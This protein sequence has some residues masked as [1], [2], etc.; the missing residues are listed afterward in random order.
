MAEREFKKIKDILSKSVYASY[1][2]KIKSANSTLQTLVEQSEYRENIWQKR[3]LPKRQLL[4]IKTTRRIAHSLYDIIARGEF[5]NCKCRDQHRAQI[6]LDVFSS[7]DFSETPE[8]PKFR[9]MLTSKTSF[10]PPVPWHWQEV[11]TES[12]IKDTQPMEPKSAS[13]K[14]KLSIT[15]KAKVKFAVVAMPL[16]SVPWPKV[17]RIP[18]GSPIENLCTTLCVIKAN[19]MREDRKLI[20]FLTDDNHRHTLYAVGD[21]SINLQLQSLEA[22]LMSSSGSRNIQGPSKIVLR[23]RDRLRLAASLASSTLRFHG[24]WMRAHWRTKDIMLRPSEDGNNAPDFIYLAQQTPENADQ[25]ATPMSQQNSLS[26]HLIR[27]ETLFPLGLA[28]VE[29]SLGQTIASLRKPEDDDPVDAVANLKTALRNLQ[30][31]RN[32]SGIVYEEVV[33]KCF[34]WP[35]RKDIKFD[36]EDFQRTMFELIVLPLLEDLKHFEGKYQI[37]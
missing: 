33:D 16:Q 26:T 13:K 32:E 30:D 24:S 25:P 20:G 34:F 28:L 3:R 5:W 19:S 15:P 2:D 14:R 11:E 8:I 37:H 6:Q 21:S 35:S 7:N 22:L 31:V 36:D 1:I 17:E 27:N 10:E 9:L 4:S 18:L 23:R 29:L 12:S